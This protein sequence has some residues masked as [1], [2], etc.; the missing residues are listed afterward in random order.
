MMNIRNLHKEPILNL[1]VVFIL[2][3]FALNRFISHQSD[4]C[5]QYASWIMQPILSAQQKWINH[6]QQKEQERIS[7][8]QALEQLRSVQ[9]ELAWTQ[10]AL[11]SAHNELYTNTLTS[12]L[13]NTNSFLMVAET[14][15]HHESPRSRRRKKRKPAAQQEHEAIP[16]K[17]MVVQQQPILLAPIVLRNI[18]DESHFVLIEGGA[19]KGIAVNMVCV[20]QNNLIGRVIEVYDHLSKVLLVTDRSCKVSAVCS[21]QKVPGIYEGANVCSRGKLCHVS[22]LYDIQCDDVVITSGEG[23]LFPRGF[24]LGR[25][26]QAERVGV[27]YEIAVKPLVD[28]RAITALAILGTKASGMD[29]SCV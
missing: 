28:I 24:M 12:A 21:K 11:I 5:E 4:M 6:W 20:Y 22:H 1:L 14:D 25:I 9:Q 7:I 2:F 23:L 17:I 26:A 16:E 29:A 8:A 3:F 15:T 18:T 10:S 27:H 13:I 19:D